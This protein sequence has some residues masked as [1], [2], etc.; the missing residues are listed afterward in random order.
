LFFKIARVAELDAEVV[1]AR[2]ILKAELKVQL[3]EA[4]EV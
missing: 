4:S 2:R 1:A 3:P